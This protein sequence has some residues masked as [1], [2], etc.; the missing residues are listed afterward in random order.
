MNRDGP[1]WFFFRG[2]LHALA[3]TYW[4]Q[5]LVEWQ[6]ADGKWQIEGENENDTRF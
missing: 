3:L 1:D 5:E 2:S 4:D 6:M